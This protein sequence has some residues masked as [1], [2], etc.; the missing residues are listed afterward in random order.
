MKEILLAD[1][2]GFVFGVKRAVDTALN[3]KK[4]YTDSIYTLGP[5]IHNHDVVEL[6]K[7]NNIYSISNDD[8]N[9]LNENDVVII[10]SHG[11]SEE[12]FNNLKNKKKIEY[13]RCN[14]SHTLTIFK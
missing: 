1:K 3:K 14:L 8:I 6:L 10:R 11:I 12:T 4:E 5:L 13:C 9:K 2:A 7:E